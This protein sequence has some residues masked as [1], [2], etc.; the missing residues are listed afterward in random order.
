MS[1]INGTRKVSRDVFNS[2]LVKN[3]NYDGMQ[4][5]PVIMPTDKL[6]GRI[7]PFSKAMKTKD[8][9]QWI[10]FYEYDCKFADVWD[11]P[12]KYISHLSKF[13]GLITPD[14]SL[15]RDMPLVMQEWNTYRG[16]ALGHWWQS[17]GLNVIPNVRWSDGRTYKFC[18]NG[19]PANATICVGSY[20]S[21]RDSRNRE[22][23]RKGLE[24]VVSELHPLCIV[25]YGGIP[26]DVFSC[27]TEEGIKLLHFPGGYWAGRKESAS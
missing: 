5:I 17:Q 25:V 23:F 2:F 20:G 1:V 4:E 13:Q 11:K 21:L 22:F 9:A 10:H 19:I 26:D 12:R 24:F 18:C 15:Y 16:K 6:P 3:A 14:F 7:I 8:F 27:C